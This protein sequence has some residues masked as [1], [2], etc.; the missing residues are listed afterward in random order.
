MTEAYIRPTGVF[1]HGKIRSDV[2][3]H[4]RNGRIRCIAP[5][6]APT[7]PRVLDGIVSPGLIDL[8]VNGGGGVLF[9][10]TPTPEGIA[11]I[12]AAHRQFGTT[13]LCPTVITD[14]PDVTEAAA[15]AVLDTWG[16]PG[17]LGI[18]IEGPH[19]ALAKR[20]THDARFIRP[21]DQRTHQLVARLRRADIPTILTLA[22]EA[23]SETDIKRLA[24]TGSVVSIGHS[25]ATA[26]QVGRAL[27]AG[28]RNFTHLYNAMSPM[29]GRAPG[30][31]GAA[32]LSDADIGIICD[33]IHV[34]DDMVDLA[35]RTH[36]AGRMHIVSDAM[37]TV[38]G[39]PNFAIYGQQITLR[40]GALINAEGSLAGA[41]TTMAEGVRRLTQRIGLTPQ[42]ALGMAITNPA[43]L[44]GCTHSVH[45]AGL[46]QLLIWKQ[47]GLPA[48]FVP[49]GHRELE[50]R[51]G[52][53]PV[54]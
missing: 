27:Q 11:T 52:G 17:L 14:A 5:D 48:F 6:A 33:G 26:A 43:R 28:A 35:I 19:I 4:I 24:D 42:D 9:N 13:G 32:L 49:S 16:M 15:Q 10:T 8:Q 29:E 3:L 1:D 46:D 36:G 53:S 22:P 50:L 18:H 2:V 31:V 12:I 51:H 40:E 25:N 41:H 44:I 21:M 45:G 7:Q 30:V 37:P 20:G 47:G 39:P 54:P 34:C 38:G 23:A